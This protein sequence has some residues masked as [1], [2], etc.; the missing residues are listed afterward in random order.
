ML[1]ILFAMAAASPNPA[2]IDAPRRNFAACIKQFEKQS[3]TAKM[4]PDAYSAAVKTA[5]PS[6][7]DAFTHALVA[8]DMAMGTKRDKAA[9]NAAMDVGDYRDSSVDRYRDSAAPQ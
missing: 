2:S 5:C 7:A 6:E 4:P 9:Q 3:L 8:Y 1:L